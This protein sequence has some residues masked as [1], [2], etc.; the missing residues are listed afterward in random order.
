MNMAIKISIKN[1][2]QTQT[3]ELASIRFFSNLKVLSYLR[4]SCFN[5]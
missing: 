5:L 3:F 4:L 1:N 2:A